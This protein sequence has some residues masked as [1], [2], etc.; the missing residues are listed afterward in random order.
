MICNDNCYQRKLLNNTL[1]D[2]IILLKNNNIDGI[3]KRK[4]S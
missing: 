3:K 2:K 4:T 1:E